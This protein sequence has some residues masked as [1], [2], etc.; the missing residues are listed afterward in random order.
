MATGVWGE[1]EL[2]GKKEEVSNIIENIA[3]TKTPCLSN[4]GREMVDN[5]E[6]QWQRDTLAAAVDTNKHV[7]GAAFSADTPAA[8]ELLRGTCEIAR[9]D[10]S[11]DERADKVS[12]YGRAKELAYQLAKFGEELKRDQEMAITAN[13]SRVASGVTTAPETAGLPAWLATNSN[14]GTSGADPALSGGHAVAAT[15]GD[16]RALSEANLKDVISQCYAEGGE[17]S[18]IQLHYTRKVLFSEFMLDRTATGGPRVAQVQ[19]NVDAGGRKGAR[20]I[21]AVDTYLSDFGLF[22]VVPSLFQRERD[23]FILDPDLF[24][25]AIFRNYHTQTM[26]KGGDSNER[27]LLVDFGL[28]SREERGSGILADISAS[29]M[30]Q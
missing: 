21:G 2:V 7:S 23:V 1:H 28:K 11:V 4:F 22:D 27:I 29:S 25:I 24:D 6:Y 14:R 5:P 15:D 16:L 13:N 12:K 20:V 9:K 8:T 17:P 10:L 19:Q 18:V 3:P 30:T 26:G